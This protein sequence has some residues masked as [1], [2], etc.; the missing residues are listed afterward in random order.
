MNQYVPVLGFE[1]TAYAWQGQRL[2][3]AGPAPGAEHPRNVM[4]PWQAPRRRYS[5]VALR[6]MPAR[7]RVFLTSNPDVHETD[8][9][10]RR[11]LL[12]WFLGGDL[13]FPLNLAPQRFNRLKQALS[14]HDVNGLSQAASALLG[15][16]PGLTPS[17]DDFV[18]GVFFALHHLPEHAFTVSLAQLQHDV[19]RQAEHATNPISASLLA[20][21]VQGSSWRAAHELLDAA[22]ASDAEL[23][24]ALRALLAVGA[25]SGGDMLA[26]LLL[27]LSVT[28]PH[29]CT[30]A[31]QPLPRSHPTISQQNAP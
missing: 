14:E 28:P 26:G 9:P 31:R 23:G 8:S 10:V 1:G 12:P 21:M 20:D 22:Q 19:L 5:A 3:W 11:G 13:P 7:C 17:G 30:T 2:V 24:R 4:R 25:S 18:G 27:A 16:G 15:L 29:S 6:A